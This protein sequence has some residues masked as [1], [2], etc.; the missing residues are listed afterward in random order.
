MCL[1]VG[2]DDILCIPWL[3]ALNSVHTHSHT[4][5]LDVCS[6]FTQ[7]NVLPLFITL[8][9]SAKLEKAE[10]LQMTVDHL[11]HLHQSRDARGRNTYKSV[12]P[13]IIGIDVYIHIY[14]HAHTRKQAHGLPIKALYK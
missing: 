1:V 14:T 2:M 4:V 3:G 9:G 11:R 5:Y 6:G 7:A 8:Q 12:H 13:S 10:I